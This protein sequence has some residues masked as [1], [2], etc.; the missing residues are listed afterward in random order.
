LKQKILYEFYLLSHK[1]ELIIPLEN[2]PNPLEITIKSNESVTDILD[3]LQELNLIKNTTSLEIYLR[4]S[5]LDKKLL[6]GRHSIQANLSPI[7][8]VQALTSAD[9]LLI[10]FTIL[11]GWRIE[12]IAQALTLSGL[13]PQQ[14][15]FI[16][17]ATQPLMNYSPDI[18][19][20]DTAP[21]EGFLLPDSYPISHGFSDEELV[22]Q[23]VNNFRKHLTPDIME[24][25]EGQ[26]LSVYD[27]VILASIVQRESINKEEMPLIASVY[28]N[29]LHADMK[30]DADPTV[31]YALGYN[32]TQKTWWT[33]PLSEQDL[34]ID[35]PYNTYIYKGLPPTPICNPSLTAIR[36][37]AFPA[38]SDFYY[39]RAACDHSGNHV[40]SKTYE[41]HILQ[42]CP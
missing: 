14:D 37:V 41:E 40:F 8:I 17:A 19:P 38:Q 1:D 23:F 5:G 26:G 22:R 4:Y 10:T 15:D 16:F 32:P 31:Q 9:N 28:L 34:Q 7:E 6:A 25:I 42:A 13:Q 30:L 20:N 3:E 21:T 2:K 33:N 36:A 35:S 11:A 24:G 18:A 12:E 29:R 27:A 39:F